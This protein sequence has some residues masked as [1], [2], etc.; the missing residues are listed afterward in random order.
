MM[1]VLAW[2]HPT[3]A[4]APPVLAAKQGWDVLL[5]ASTWLCGALDAPARIAEWLSQLQQYL[6]AGCSQML[7]GTSDSWA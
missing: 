2:W 1:S 4:Q 3:L 7:R 6:L 5:W